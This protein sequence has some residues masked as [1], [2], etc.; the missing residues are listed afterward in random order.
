MRV[1][2]AAI[3]A[4]L[5]GASLLGGCAETRLATYAAKEVVQAFP[6]EKPAGTYKV[7]KPYQIKGVWYYPQEVNEYDEVGIASWYG[8]AFHGKTT[9]NGEAFDMNALTAAHKTLPLPTNVRVTNLD[10]GRSIVLRVNDRGPFVGDRII[11][12]SRRAAQLLGFEHSGLA[13]VEVTLAE[14]QGRLPE[15][16]MVEAKPV[17]KAEA[18]LVL[19]EATERDVVAAAA[20]VRPAPV[21]A[22]RVGPPIRLIAPV[23]A[24]EL[25]QSGPA[26]KVRT[27]TAQAAPIQATPAAYHPEPQTPAPFAKAAE[28]T[29]YVQAG[30]FSVRDNADGLAAE[31]ADL[32]PVAIQ[33]VNRT[34][35]TFYR[36]RVGPFQGFEAAGKILRAVVASGQ[37]NARLV[38]E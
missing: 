26:P 17:P 34:D 11:D 14:P 19:A 31:L 9:A 36:V 27:R 16:R 21:R 22:E 18:A 29:L 1:R 33:P 32:G 35:G 5:V 28:E 10:N 20:P 3:L 23:A 6:E 24:A 2:H 12:V 25:E 13:R 30:A 4:T 7:G 8:D 37:T 15:T 38:A